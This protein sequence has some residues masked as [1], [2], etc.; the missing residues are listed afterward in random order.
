[1]TDLSVDEVMEKVKSIDPIPTLED[2]THFQFVQD[3][4]D[5]YHI[6]HEIIQKIKDFTL[7]EAY[8]ETNQETYQ[9]MEIFNS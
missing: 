3:I 7:N 1:M 5:A 9:A 8:L 4:L 2:H 6:N